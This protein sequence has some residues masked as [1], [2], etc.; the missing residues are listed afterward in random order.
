[1]ADQPFNNHNRPENEINN[2]P[3]Q[4]AM[5]RITQHG[6][7]DT[8][9]EAKYAFHLSPSTKI[10]IAFSHLVPFDPATWHQTL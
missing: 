3:K 6:S 10:S 5:N 9:K 1:M 2:T 7:Y 4:T 8:D